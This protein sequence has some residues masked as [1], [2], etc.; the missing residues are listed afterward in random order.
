M[1][2][3]GVLLSVVLVLA[4]PAVALACPICFQVEENAVTDGVQSAVLVLVGVTTSV[5]SGFGVFIARFVRRSR[6]Q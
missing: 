3:R 1:I 6:G 2:R 4:V 5:L